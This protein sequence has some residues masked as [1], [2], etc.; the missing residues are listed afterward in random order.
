LIQKL[1]CRT[2]IWLAFLMN[3]CFVLKSFHN[4]AL[5]YSK[6]PYVMKHEHAPWLDAIYMLWCIVKRFKQYNV[7]CCF[8]VDSSSHSVPILFICSRVFIFPVMCCKT[9]VY[10]PCYRLLQIHTKILLYK[11]IPFGGNWYFEA[12]YPR[13][14]SIGTSH[15][16]LWWI[17]MELTL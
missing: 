3:N 16:V 5:I 7:R 14:N 15:S 13:Q 11:K 17:E 1:S 9:I 12:N 8:H 2:C 6:H 4:V 10:Y